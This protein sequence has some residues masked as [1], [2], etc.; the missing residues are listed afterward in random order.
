MQCQQHQTVLNV[1]SEKLQARNPEAYTRAAND[2]LA[3]AV[4]AL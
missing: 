3:A 1:T 4:H 2:A